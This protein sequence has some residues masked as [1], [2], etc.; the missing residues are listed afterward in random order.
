MLT[1]IPGELLPKYWHMFAPMIQRAIDASPE[2]DYGL[3]HVYSQIRSKDAQLWA[4]IE[5][6]EVS[7]CFVGMVC[8]R[9][10]RKIY[11]VPLIGGRGL[12]AWR[13]GADGALGA[14]AKSRGCDRMEGYDVRGGAWLRALVGWKKIAIVIRREL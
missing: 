7:A 14:F 8:I 10:N 2:C 1:G 6:G 11:A 9:P 5:R 12:K 13:R 3:D 4:W